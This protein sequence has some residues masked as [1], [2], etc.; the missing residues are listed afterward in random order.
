MILSCVGLIITYVKNKK[1]FYPLFFLAIINIYVLSCWW[2]WWF[3]GS[4]GM[5]P[6]IDSYGF[7][8]ISL[9]YFIHWIWNK[10]VI[11][12]TFVGGAMIFLFCLNIF[13][14]QQRRNL[15]IHWDSMSKKSYWNYF[16]TLKFKAEK[17]WGNQ[18]KLLLHPD[19]EKA[20]KGEDEYDFSP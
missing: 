15:V 12:K 6:M 8:A 19:Y 16:T 3:G 17:D 4:F 11:L 10:K 13:Q 20:I 14:T 5:R 2:C 7:F 18:E 1:I 9:G